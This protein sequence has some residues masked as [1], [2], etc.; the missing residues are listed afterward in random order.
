[1]LSRVRHAS[2]SS[3]MDGCYKAMVVVEYNKI[4]DA[5]VRAMLGYLLS[6]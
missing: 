6:G 1:M 4:D 5:A 2:T 3:R